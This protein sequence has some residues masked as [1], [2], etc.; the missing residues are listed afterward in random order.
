MSPWVGRAMDRKASKRRAAAI[1][2][3]CSHPEHVHPVAR[4]GG[5]LVPGCGCAGYLPPWPALVPS[6]PGEGADQP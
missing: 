3:R 6:P 1:C 2:K 5:C 4:D